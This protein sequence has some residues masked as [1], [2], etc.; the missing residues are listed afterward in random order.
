VNLA[1]ACLIEADLV[2]A[3]L[4]LAKI[5][6]ADLSSADLSYADLTYADMA[7]A[8]LSYVS[9][10]HSNL[11]GANLRQ[12]NLEWAILRHANLSYAT[13]EGANLLFAG[14]SFTVL[15]A[16]D[17]RAVRNLEF[18]ILHGPSSIGIDTIYRSR[19]EIPESFLKGAGV[20]DA[21]I[22]Y[23]RSLVGKAIEFYSCFISYSHADKPFASRLYET[24]QSRGIRCW[25]DEHQVLP[26]DD[27]YEQVDRGIRFWDK[28]LLCCS[29]SSLRSWWVDNE[30]GTAFEKEQQLMKERGQ[31]VL[32][33]IPLNLDGYLLSGNWKSGKATQVLQRLAANFTGWEEDDGK[34]EAQIAKVVRALR[35]DEGA[36]PAAPI[37]RI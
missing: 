26:G 35:A 8:N 10:L 36:R 33:L 31:K 34:F 18:V 6:E 30:I 23:A 2:D 16:I 19:G 21:V 15:A 24:L 27:I 9:F 5:G 22:T 17:L 14:L 37:S 28:V 3:R 13:L 12:A 11:T 1:G 29:E 4:S 32:A 7:E 20:P 25:L